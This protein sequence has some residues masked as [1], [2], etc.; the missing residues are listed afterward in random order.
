MITHCVL[1]LKH[2]NEQLIVL[3]QQLH[4]IYYNKITIQAV[5]ARPQVQYSK[6]NN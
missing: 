5:L 4:G 2:H 1:I 3:L 6:K